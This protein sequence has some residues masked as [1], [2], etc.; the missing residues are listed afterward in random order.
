[1]QMFGIGILELMVIMVLA[2]LVIGPDRVPQFAADLARWIR[3]AR[4]YANHL[5]KDFNEVVGDLEKEVGA[6]REDW[7]EIASVVNR[8]TG[9]VVREVQGVANTIENSV[10]D[11]ATLAGSAVPSAN[12]TSSAQP[13]ELPAIAPARPSVSSN[14]TN[15]AASPSATVSNGHQTN[16]PPPIDPP[17]QASPL[18]EARPGDEPEQPWY[19]PARTARR[20]SLD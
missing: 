7:K 12:G 14:S 10:P 17:E 19:V 5:M 8:H 15:G 18:G 9:S 16:P 2:V 20:R 4:S 3:Q 6:S 1:M 11:E 13:I